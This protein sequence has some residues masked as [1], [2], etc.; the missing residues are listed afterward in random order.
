MIEAY[1]ARP[2]GSLP[3]VL[4]GTRVA[5]YRGAVHRSQP[6]IAFLGVFDTV[7]ALG[8]PGIARRRYAFHDVR[9]GGIVDCA[10][11]ALAIDER[12]RVFA[13]SVW[14][15]GEE[16]DVDVCQ[17]WFEG[18]HSDIGGGYAD[19]GP[20][21]LTLRWMVGEAAARGLA[22]RWDLFRLA[23]PAAPLIGHESLIPRYW[24]HNQIGSATEIVRRLTGRPSPRGSGT[25]A[26]RS[27]AAVTRVRYGSRGPPTTGERWCRCNGGSSQRTSRDG[28]P[29]T[30]ATYRWST[31]P[32]LRSCD[33]VIRIAGAMARG[34]SPTST[35]T[36]RSGAGWRA[37]RLPANDESGWCS[38]CSAEGTR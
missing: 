13:P 31:Y 7:G 14:E 4:H 12:R 20:A 35:M 6:R 19:H 38:N 26:A 1:R 21:D 27:S 22:F 2:E 17:V 15:A 24:V 11:H 32:P 18:A 34:R 9:L 10:R 30:T 37:A 8:V 36:I 29:S 28:S 3:E 33:C 5:R 23:G 16:T 25:V